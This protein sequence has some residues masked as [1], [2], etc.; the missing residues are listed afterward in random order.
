M[1]YR[2][3]ISTKVRRLTITCDFG[4][5]PWWTGIRDENGTQVASL[6]PDALRELRDALSRII[7]AQDLETHREY[8]AQ[9]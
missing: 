3:A 7:A 5:W 8:H 2:V 1:A 9:R 4:G 6:D